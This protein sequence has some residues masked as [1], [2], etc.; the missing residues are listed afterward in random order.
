MEMNVYQ[1]IAEVM[2]EVEYLTKDDYVETGKGRGYKAVT[3]EKVTTAVRQA[4]IKHGIV[5]IPIGIDRTTTNETVV[6]KYGNQKTNHLVE[7]E[8]QYRIQNVD[9]PGDYVIAVSAGSGVDTQDKAVGKAL[10]YSYK[11]LLLRTFAVPTGEDSDKV[12]SAKI[13]AE[14]TPASNTISAKEYQNLLDLCAK[15]GKTEEWLH[16]K[17]NVEHGAEITKAQYAEAVMYFAD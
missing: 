7:T 5:I 9:D 16:K 6:D 15:N 14:L 11:Y 8:N 12:A 4:M 17:C 10:T 13:D 3:E 1:R 2:K